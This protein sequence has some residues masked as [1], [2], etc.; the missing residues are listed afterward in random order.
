LITAYERKPWD[1]SAIGGP[2][3]GTLLDSV[4]QEIDIA[5][6]KEVFTWRASEHFAIT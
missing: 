5:T 2:R 3:N 1:L 4:F 6:G